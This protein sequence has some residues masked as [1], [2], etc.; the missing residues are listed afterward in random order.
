[1]AIDAG[2]ARRIAALARLELS[3]EEI[4]RA[5]LQ[6]SQILE[7]AA[8]LDTLDLTGCEPTA[9]APAGEPLR[10]DVTD[11]R[12]FGAETATL[13][14]PESE[15]GFFLV[16]PVVENLERGSVG[17]CRGGRRGRPGAR[18]RGGRTRGWGRASGGRRAGGRRACTRSCMPTRARDGPP[19]GAS[20]ARCRSQAC[21]CSSRTTCARRT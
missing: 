14:A 11:G 17:G 4:A 5:A 9:F 12:T 6:L 16:P 3:E 7:F 1:M 15:Y 10:P 21:P 13:G 19:H 18:G 8:M 2:E 20:T